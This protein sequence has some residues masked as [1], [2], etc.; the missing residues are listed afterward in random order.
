MNYFVDEVYEL[1]Y[2]RT[3]NKQLLTI[4]DAKY[5]SHIQIK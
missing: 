4:L 3:P 5:E 1:E 2:L